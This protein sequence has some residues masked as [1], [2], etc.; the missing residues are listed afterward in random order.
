MAPDRDRRRWLRAAAALPA[1]GLAGCVPAPYGTY[2][3][4]STTTPDAQLRRAYCGGKAG[5]VSRVEFGAAGLRFE[6]RVE[7]KD[8]G[9]DET[10]LIAELTVP[11]G[12]ELTLDGLIQL[13][14]A[15]RAADVQRLLVAHRGMAVQPNTWI[16]PQVLRPGTAAVDEKA[17]FGTLRFDFAPVPAIGPRIVADGLRLERDGG[18]FEVPPAALSRPASRSS[19]DTY[20]TEEE[21]AVLLERAQACR[22]DT[23]KR[24]CENIVEYSEGSDSGTAGGTRWSLRWY[25]SDRVRGGA[26][27]LEGGGTLMSL[28]PGRWRLSDARF[29][30]RD[31][32]GSTVHPV[33]LQSLRLAFSDRVVP[34]RPI[35]ASGVETRVV[36]EAVLPDGLPD[37]DLVFPSMRAGSQTI[38]LPPVQF[39]RRSFDGGIEPFNC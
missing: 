18:G 30:V 22:R 5:P 29:R 26:R 33:R 6:A 8:M 4:P 39:E 21:Q 20:R 37:F 13:R 24:A 34:G 12:T 23:P 35:L 17:P 14:V 2:Y 3:R 10:R 19:P 28:Q 36:F 25:E 15:Q 31:A 7:M 11:P 9:H 1:L 32:A 16:D 27:L 38:S